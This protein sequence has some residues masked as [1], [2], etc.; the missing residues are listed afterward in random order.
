MMR[1]RSIGGGDGLAHADVVERRTRGVEHDAVRQRAP[2]TRS[3]GATDR[4]RRATPSS[5]R[6]RRRRARR[7]RVPRTSSSARR[8]PR[9]RGDATVGGPPSSAESPACARR[10]SVDPPHACGNETVRCRPG[11]CCTVRGACPRAERW[12]SRCAGKIGSSASIGGNPGGGDEK[13]MRTVESSTALASRRC[14]RGRRSAG[15][16][17]ARSRA[18]SRVKTTSRAV[19]GSP[20]CHLSTECR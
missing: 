7:S 8:R 10:P 14:S 6:C 12:T 13:R 1:L 3:R 16:P 15:Y 20:S 18:A 19:V 9:R 11:S 2:D 4:A 5:A 17:V